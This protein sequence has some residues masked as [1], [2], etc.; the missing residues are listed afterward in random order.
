MPVK[1][2]EMCSKEYYIIEDFNASLTS[3]F[4]LGSHSVTFNCESC[5][6]QIVNGEIIEK[7]YGGVVVIWP[8]YFFLYLGGNRPACLLNLRVVNVVAQQ[9][10]VN[11]T[12]RYWAPGRRHLEVPAASYGHKVGRRHAGN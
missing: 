5:N 6:F 11:K 1:A 10:T 7:Q 3:V 2:M 8:K 9:N 4:D 12:I